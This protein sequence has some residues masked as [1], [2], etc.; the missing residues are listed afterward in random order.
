MATLR[1]LPDRLINQIAAGEVVERPA[2]ALKELVENA[3]DAGARQTS[4]KLRRGGIDEITVLDDGCGMSADEMVLSVQRHAT[5]KLPDNSLDH[6]NSLGFRGEALPSI[7]AVSRLSLTSITTDSTHAWRIVVDGGRMSDPQPAALAKGSMISVT[8]LFKAVPARLK[9]LKTERTE[10][11][12]CLDIVRRLALAWPSVGFHL[13]AD[14]RVL[15]DLPACLP[16]QGGLQARIGT[17]MGQSFASEAIEFEA[18]RDDISLKGFAG[19]PT[20]NRPTTA[21]IFLFVNGRP[22]RDRALLGAIRAGYGDT[23]PRGRH[24]MA[25]LFLYVPA[26]SVDVNVHPAKAEVRFK[27]AAAVRS[28]LVGGLMASLSDGSIQATGAGGEAAMGKFS[29]GLFGAPDG[30]TGAGETSGSGE[31]GRPG[32]P[33]LSSER[34]HAFLTQASSGQLSSALTSTNSFYQLDSVPP[35]GLPNTDLLGDDTVPAARPAFDAPH[36]EADRVHRK[37][38]L[39]AA[40]AQLHKTYIVAETEDGLT[41]IDQHAA[42]ERLVMER[43]KLALAEKQVASQTLLLPEVVSLADHY[44]AA[45]VDAAEMLESMGLIVENFGAG[46]VVVRAIPALLGTPDV[47]QLIADIAEELVELGGSTSLEDR[48]NHVLATVSCHGSVRAGRPLNGAEMN[49]LLR[50]MEGT[51]R[52]GQCNHGRPTWIALSLADIER[53]FGRG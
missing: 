50:D 38:L 3:L 46:A 40:R 30:V 49:A 35:A 42:H 43:M 41:I 25:I 52:S 53:L 2:S 51:P 6:I 8:Q 4:I 7:G 18:V 20:M 12:Q 44:A 11:G 15:L 1:Q 21:N 19:L 32:N 34:R 16:G 47:K 48:I 13:N 33:M 45:L 10:Q 5:S 37:H 28:L 39:G 23:L 14:D 29:N 24:P 22:I 9:F 31:M 27:D 36:N 17:I 26:S